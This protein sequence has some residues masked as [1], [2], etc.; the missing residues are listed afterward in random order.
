M[1]KPSCALDGEVAYVSEAVKEHASSRMRAVMKRCGID[2]S[3]ETSEFFG[4]H[5][6]VFGVVYTDKD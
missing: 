3:H 2:V 6:L 4:F 5:A 1:A